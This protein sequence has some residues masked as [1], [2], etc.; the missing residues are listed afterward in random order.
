MSWWLWTGTC[1]PLVVMIQKNQWPIY[2][3][4]IGLS[5]LTIQYFYRKRRI[6]SS[7]EHRGKVSHIMLFYFLD[8]CSFFAFVPRCGWLVAFYTPIKSRL[9]PCINFT[10]WSLVLCNIYVSLAFSFIRRKSWLVGGAMQ[11]NKHATPCL[12][13]LG[14]F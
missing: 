14:T 9:K 10:A 7:S 3:N 11:P 2:L 8:I 4:I 5:K 12:T 13:H 1:T 6:F